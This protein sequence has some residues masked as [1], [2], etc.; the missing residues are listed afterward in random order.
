M[1][2]IGEF[3]ALIYLGVTL[4]VGLSAAIFS[5]QEKDFR[6]NP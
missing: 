3:V 5:F 6:Y 1:G 2:K 4:W